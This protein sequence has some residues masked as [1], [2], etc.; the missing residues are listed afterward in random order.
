MLVLDGLA[1]SQINNK[2]YDRFLE[3]LSKDRK[4][5]KIYLRNGIFLKGFIEFF[6]KAVLILKDKKT[7]LI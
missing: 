1:K 5:A 7:I 6:D 2:I 4:Q 3:N